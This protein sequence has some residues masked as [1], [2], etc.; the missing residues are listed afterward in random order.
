MEDIKSLSYLIGAVGVIG[1]FSFFVVKYIVNKTL[2]GIEKNAED[3]QLLK[4]EYVKISAKVDGHDSDIMETK[5]AWKTSND[6]M[7]ALSN[8]IAKFDNNMAIHHSEMKT[9]V[10]DN[11]K[12]MNEVV[13]HLKIR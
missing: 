13:Q 12:V 2:S 7:L 6:T 9:L 8:T 10:S 11:T 1:L 3:I 4:I 5:K